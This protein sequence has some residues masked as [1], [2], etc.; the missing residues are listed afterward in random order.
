MK[1][2]TRI[3]ETDSEE[4][5]NTKTDGN[6]GNIYGKSECIGRYD[7]FYQTLEEYFGRNVSKIAVTKSQKKYIMYSVKT[8]T[9]AST[10]EQEADN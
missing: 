10:R 3:R 8:S 7:G 2:R 6:N 5:Q 4:T 9:P 1:K